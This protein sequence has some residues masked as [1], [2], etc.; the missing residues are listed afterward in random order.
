MDIEQ[1][2]G[3]MQQWVTGYPDNPWEPCRYIAYKDLDWIPE[4]YYTRLG[5]VKPKVTSKTL[6][7]KNPKLLKVTHSS[8]LGPFW[9][10][11]DGEAWLN[12]VPRLN[13][14]IDEGNKEKALKLVDMFNAETALWHSMY[15]IKWNWKWMDFIVERYGYNELYYA[16]RSLYSRM[17]PPLAPDEPKP[18][19]ASIPSAEDRARKAAAWGRGDLSGPNAE[20][21]VR[22]IDEPD[23][24]VMELNPCGSG[25]RGLIRVEKMDDLIVNIAEDLKMQIYMQLPITPLTEPPFNFKSTTEAHPVAQGKVGIPHFCTRCFVHFEMAAIAR[26]GYLTTV[27]E[28]PENHTDP[29]CRWFFYKDLDDIPEKYY[30]RIGARKPARQP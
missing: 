30:T 22:I 1:T 5:K 19:K 14:A 24:I 20:G 23:R 18:T 4:E 15:P 7:P 8:E 2:G 11:T 21:S 9:K 27:V 3:Y 16:L 10:V 6:A 26:T 17:E 12:M 28:R 13:K 29:N 25:G